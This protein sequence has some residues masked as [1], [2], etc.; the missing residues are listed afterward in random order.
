[1]ENSL[2]GRI[3]KLGALSRWHHWLLP[4]PG[5]GGHLEN[6]GEKHFKT[7]GPLLFS[8]LEMCS[9]GCWLHG[10]RKNFF[11][12]LSTYSTSA[13]EFL[14]SIIHLLF[15][16]LGGRSHRQGCRVSVPSALEAACGGSSPTSTTSDLSEF[17]RFAYLTFISFKK[18]HSSFISM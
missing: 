10:I 6:L 3:W 4:V 2:K 15:T 16:A 5:T 14:V 9:C 7:S 17:G 11:P 1:M 8:L 12:F 18:Y 13:T